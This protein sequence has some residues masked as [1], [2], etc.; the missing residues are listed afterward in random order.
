MP[1]GVVVDGHDGRALADV[2]ISDGVAVTRTAA[3]GSFALPAHADAQFVWVCV[4]SSHRAL[5]PG[6]FVDI[7]REVG[8]DPIRFVLEPRVE[9]T[10]GCHFAQVTDLHVSVDAG[11]RLRPMLEGGLVAPP[12][13]QVTGET[14]SAELREDLEAL[15]A[16]AAPQFVVATGDLADYGQPEELAA[17]LAAIADLGVPVAS[18]PGNHDH[19]SSLTRQAIEEFFADWSTRDTEGLD[20]SAIFQKEVFGGD[21]RR[22]NSGRS[23][24]LDALGPLYYSFDWGDVHFVV[25]DGEGLRRYGGDYPQDRWLAGDLAAVEAGTPVVVCTHFLEEAEFYRSRFAG[26]RLVASL[27]GHWHGTRLWIDGETRHWTSA[28]VG[29]GGIDFT[30]RG[31]RVVD[32]DTKGASSTWTPIEVPFDVRVVG[33][34]A[35]AAGRIFVAMERGDVSGC[36]RALDGWT[37]EL[38]IAARGGVAAG[39]GLVFAQDLVGVL[40]SLDATTGELRW[41]AQLGEPSSRWVLGTPVVDGDTVFAGS[42]ADVHAFDARTG[43]PQWQTAL[44]ASDWAVSWSGVAIA[45]DTLVIGAVNDNLHLAA[46]DKATGAVRWWHTGRDIAG[47]CT[48]PVVTDGGVIAAH[49]NGWLRAYGSED[50][51]QLWECALD[52]AWPVAVA[53]AADLAVVRSAT[54]VVTAHDAGTG[55]LRWHGSLGPGVRAGRPYSRKLGGARVPLVV[56]GAHVWTA[57]HDELVRLDVPSGAVQRIPVGAEIATVGRADDQ[58]FAIAADG[59]YLAHEDGE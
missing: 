11:A 53:L 31:Y 21:W 56:V 5:A 54:G 25:Y 51:A 3:D 45:D 1:A 46:L 33:P 57:A 42:A 23:P 15:V 38:P 29:F 39:N 55:E 26:V 37:H 43:S 6:W 7:R 18:V 41:S 14:T 8:N 24:W 58:V 28:N 22:P 12:G 50:G 27:S 59:R 16:S 49:A 2:V 47:V 48:T 13:V 17:Y 44:A 35:T 10:S 30:P 19:L 32:V 34:A 4:P 36:V 40:H 9:Q 52:D 20:V